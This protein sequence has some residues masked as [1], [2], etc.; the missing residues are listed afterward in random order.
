MWDDLD[1]FKLPDANMLKDKALS[2]T[3]LSETLIEITNHYLDWAQHEPDAKEEVNKVKT[4]ISILE[5]AYNQDLQVMLAESFNLIPEKL[6]KNRDLQVGW[7]VNNY[8]TFVKASDAIRE[9]KYL[10]V[11]KQAK[12][13]TIQAKMAAAKQVLDVGRS[14]LSAMKEELRNLS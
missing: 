13:D 2:T 5:K 6:Q 3:F 4:S 11:E 7:I 9:Q 10:L 1:H 14:I 8:D 12:L